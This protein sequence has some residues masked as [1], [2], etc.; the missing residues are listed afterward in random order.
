MKKVVLLVVILLFFTIAL[1]FS[2]ND[3]SVAPTVPTITASTFALY[4]IAKHVGGDNVDVQMV[5]PFGV[6]VHSFEPTPKTIISIQKSALFLYSGAALEPWIIKLTQG[7]NML[8]MS[9][10][11]D[12]REAQ[13]E[14]DVDDG[15]HHHGDEAV[16]PHYWLDI[17]NMKLL[18]QKIALAFVKLDK[19]HEALYVQR[20]AAYIDELTKL[21]RAY[22][23]RLQQCQVREVI[24]HHNIL[25]YVASKYDFSVQPLTGLSPDALADAQ[26]MARLSTIIKEKGIKVLFFEAFI[27]DRLMQTLAKENGVEIDYLEPLANITAAQAQTGMSYIDGMYVNLDKL[28]H[29]MRCE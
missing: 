26:T 11:V 28:T 13:G 14:G 20:A 12:L 6:E 10:Y 22:Q 8:D 17:G 21:D 25:G 3:K 16:D 27:S 4:D 2:Q 7:E 9:K 29:A 5:I 24:L 15:H 19:A 18:T 23:K 1:F